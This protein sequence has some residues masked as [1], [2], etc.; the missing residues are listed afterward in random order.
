MLSCIGSCGELR[1]VDFHILCVLIIELME[2]RQ[3]IRI[4]RF[5]YSD[6]A[7]KYK[8]HDVISNVTKHRQPRGGGVLRNMNWV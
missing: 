4:C 1:E 8:I 5:V 6:E 3:K 2:Y 7:E